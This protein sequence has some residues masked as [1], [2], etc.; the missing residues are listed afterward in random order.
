MKSFSFI[1]DIKA[2]SGSNQ[3][4]GVRAIVDGSKVYK[5]SSLSRLVKAVQEEW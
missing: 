4:L 2:F 3:N 1:S 5:I